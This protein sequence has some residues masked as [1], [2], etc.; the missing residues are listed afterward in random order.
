MEREHGLP[1]PAV[2]RLNG[3]LG[4]DHW[5]Q[6]IGA[7]TAATEWQAWQGLLGL[8]NRWQQRCAWLDEN[9]GHPQWQ[10][11]LPLGEQAA[12]EY[13]A[14]IDFLADWWDV[15]TAEIVE[16]L[17]RVEGWLDDCGVCGQGG[18]RNAERTLGAAG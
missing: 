18:Q 3:L 1:Q 10:E 16:L 14:E 6:L 12:R 4:P 17:G 9:P 7:E 13:G 2:G 8:R 11:R 5:E 15:S